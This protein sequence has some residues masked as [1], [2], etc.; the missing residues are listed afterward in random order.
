[1]RFYIKENSPSS[2]T[3][4]FLYSWKNEEKLEDKN[5]AMEF[6]L[7]IGKFLRG[8]FSNIKRLDLDEDKKG[9]C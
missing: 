6:F 1:M 3:F 9:D 5:V 2:G 7:V 8:I 4:L